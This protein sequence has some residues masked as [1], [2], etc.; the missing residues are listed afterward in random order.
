[1]TKLAGNACFTEIVTAPLCE[2]LTLSCVFQEKTKRDQRSISRQNLTIT[3]TYM[4]V[5]EKYTTYIVDSYGE[6]EI[7]QN[8]RLLQNIIR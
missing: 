5:I 2:Y 8:C 1:M 6:L 7:Q 4:I 3:I